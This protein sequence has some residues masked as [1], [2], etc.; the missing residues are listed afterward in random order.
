[1]NNRRNFDE[2]LTTSSADP[3][4]RPH[5]LGFGPFV[6][7]L[8][9]GRL[10]EGERVV[11]LAPKPFET[12][13]YLAQRSGRVISKTE[14]VQR[15]WPDTFVTEDVLVQCI[16]EIRRALG[17]PAKSPHYVQTLPRRGYQFMAPVQVL[18]AAEAPVLGATEA[19][20]RSPTE[21]PAQTPGPRSRRRVMAAAGT[22]LFG[23]AVIAGW[24][25]GVPRRLLGE[26]RQP[27]GSRSSA[28]TG[29]QGMPIAPNA[30]QADGA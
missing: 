20:V 6:A 8:E 15:L 26:E 25:T 16:M 14:L 10:S 23:A 21:A 28:E 12:L 18:S 22:L 3:G 17:D 27:P 1:M 30:P 4:E 29:S 19:P 7:D 11:P 5:R 2:E 13:C 24:L 9:T